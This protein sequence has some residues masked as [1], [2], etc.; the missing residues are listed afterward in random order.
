MDLHT[1]E[2]KPEWATVPASKRNVWQKAAANTAGIVTIG[3]FFSV[4]G[5]LSIPYGLMLIGNESFILAAVVLALGRLCDLA[6]GWLADRTG[7][8][9]PLGEKIDASFDKIST[10]VIIVG[11]AFL[12]TVTAAV[13]GLLIAPHAIIAVLALIAFSKDRPFHPSLVGKLSMAAIWATI[14]AFVLLQPLEG[15]A[16][17]TGKLL[18]YCLLCLSV[19][20]GLVAL[21]GYILEL[22]KTP[23]KS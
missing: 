10:A 14:L 3:N 17:D 1:V 2:G 5:L 21:I 12:G 15:E 22:Y 20:L 6:D 8:K 23:R 4:L 19:G 11:L 18:A 16:A 7:T 13:V 9:S